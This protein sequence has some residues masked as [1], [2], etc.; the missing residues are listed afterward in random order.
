M[1]L[2]GPGWPQTHGLP[3]L[4]GVHHISQPGVIL[5]I[6]QS[7]RKYLSSI[8]PYRAGTDQRHWPALGPKI[9]FCAVELSLM[10]NI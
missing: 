5:G 10:N 6:G 2:C 1:S 4:S 8:Y 3:G 7:F 9:A